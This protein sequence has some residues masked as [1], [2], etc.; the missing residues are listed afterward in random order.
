MQCSWFL[1]LGETVLDR[2]LR[3]YAGGDLELVQS[4]GQI[5]VCLL[6]KTKELL[7]L[8]AMRIASGQCVDAQS[9]PRHATVD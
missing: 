6:G 5:V 9:G 1:V 8:R 7:I 4:S 3:V 2:I